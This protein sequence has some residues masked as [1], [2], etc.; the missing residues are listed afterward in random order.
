MTT[1]GMWDSDEN[2]IEAPAGVGISSR[3]DEQVFKNI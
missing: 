1:P 2:L 3:L